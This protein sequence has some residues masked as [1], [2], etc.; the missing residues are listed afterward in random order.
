M[1][2][3]LLALLA[4]AAGGFL[5]A[6]FGGLIAFV[7][8]GVM[9]FVGIAIAAAGGDPTFINAIAW[10]PFMGPHIAFLAGLVAAAYAARR[11][12]LPGGGRDIVTPLVS[13]GRPDVLLVGALSGVVAYL[14]QAGL[15]AIPGL[16]TKTDTIAATILIVSIIA[17]LAFG[18][19]GLIGANAEGLTGMKRFKTNAQNAWLPWQEKPLQVG[20][21]GL[22][23][24]G[25][26]AWGTVALMT[27]YPNAAGSVMY[28]GFALS[29]F[30]L[31]LLVVGVAVP[32]THHITLQSSLALIL[33][34]S[35]WPDTSPLVLVLV[36]ALVGCIAALVAEAFS[37]LFLIRGD[38]HIDP[39]TW[40][41]WL[42][43]TVMYIVIPML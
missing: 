28:L 14:M 12:V 2:I 11:G 26:S 20:L 10:G 27:A 31:I 39:P 13:L 43:A 24:G 29:A 36:G 8:V 40:A 7:F 33:V 3:D 23:L 38:T 37:R 16:G 4:S 19:T 6:T 1:N 25:L 21:M 18:K 9:L 15:V 41:N 17:R 5:G 42:V 34:V 30:A 32:V 35:K 22:F